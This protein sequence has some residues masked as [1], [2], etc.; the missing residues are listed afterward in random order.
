MGTF[1][2]D[3]IVKDKRFGSL[4][5]IK[6][7]MLL[8]PVT[9]FATITM[10]DIARQWHGVDLRIGE[11][12]RSQARQRALFSAGATT[13]KNVGVHH[14]GL[15]CDLWIYIGG[16]PSWKADYSILGPLAAQTNMIWGGD[17]AA[18]NAPHTFRDY[19]HIQR[20]S[21]ADQTKLFAGTW[22]PEPGYV[23]HAVG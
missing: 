15:A 5:A 14:Y 17:W 6:D 21:L 23:A 22:Y 2:N 8:E 19:D 10:M 3:V 9:R 18:P 16:I 20:I 12:Y 1:Y 13:L 11:T 7:P 4:S